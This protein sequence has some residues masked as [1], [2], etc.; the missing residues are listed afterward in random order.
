MSGCFPQLFLCDFFLQFFL[1]LFVYFVCLVY[2]VGTHVPQ[3]MREGGH[4]L[5]ESV[6]PSTVGVSDPSC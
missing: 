4:S 5:W 1:N 6:S 2:A 3:C